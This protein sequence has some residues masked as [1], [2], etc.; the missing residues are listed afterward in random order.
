MYFSTNLLQDNQL[1]FE[2]FCNSRFPNIADAGGD[3]D[4][5][6]IFESV[7]DEGTTD[8]F[9]SFFLSNFGFVEWVNEGAGSSPIFEKSA[10]SDNRFFT[11]FSTEIT[12]CPFLLLNIY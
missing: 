10:A 3:D 6:Y 7:D 12:T 4:D 8:S 2:K 1:Q 5:N 9:L 11:R